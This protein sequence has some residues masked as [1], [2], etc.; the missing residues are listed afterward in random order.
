MLQQL[1]LKS[2]SM[3]METVRAFFFPSLLHISL[4]LEAF[5]KN[6]GCIRCIDVET[7]IVM[8]FKLAI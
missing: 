8:Y 3:R 2:V 6:G 5:N 7:V 1:I 4:T